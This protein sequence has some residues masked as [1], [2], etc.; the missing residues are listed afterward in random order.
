MA[1]GSTAGSVSSS[2]GGF[3]ARLILALN[4]TGT[5][6][7]VS[8]SF[9]SIYYG[10]PRTTHDIDIVVEFSGPGLRRFL[11]RLPEDE[12]YVSHEAAL[13]AVR[14]RGQFNVIDF[15]TG[16]KVDL[17]QRKDREFSETEF[18]RRQPAE[19]AGVQVHIASVEDVV[20]SKLEWSLK[21]GSKRQIDDVVGVLA[22]SGASL[23]QAY[24]ELWAERLGVAGL[25]KEATASEEFAERER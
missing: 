4:E 2:A 17:I 8:G 20:L 16:W 25:W 5:P 23:D 24:I 3:L 13:A 14:G 15:E 21:S 9:A 6:H 7:M 11:A 10:V 19:L 18:A 22:V 12:Y 1:D